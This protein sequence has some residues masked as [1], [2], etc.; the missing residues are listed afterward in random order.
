M[1]IEFYTG[2]RTW[3]GEFSMG[4]VSNLFSFST[5]YELPSWR[6]SATALQYTSCTR[7]TVRSMCIVH[8]L[9]ERFGSC[10]FFFDILS[11][12]MAFKI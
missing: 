2:A 4:S 3:Q 7:F 10:T 9:L 12:G 11:N 6:I 5:V 1:C 8:A